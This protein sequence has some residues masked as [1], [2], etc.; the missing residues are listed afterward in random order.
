MP[1][2]DHRWSRRIISGGALALAGGLASAGL[3]A[4]GLQWRLEAQVPVRCAI[5]SVE[6]PAPATTSLAI[7]TT[8]NAQ[9]YQLVVQ[10]SAQQTGLRAAQSSAGPVK[11]SGSAVTI[12]AAR[13]GYAL[14]TVELTAPVDAARLSVTL[15]PV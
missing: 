8:C 5:L 12:I 10:Q 9:R 11:I 1:Q 4:N 2:P 7:A 3:A 6:S 13:P 15:Q 14:T